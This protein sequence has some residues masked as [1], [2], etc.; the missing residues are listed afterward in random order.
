MA[1]ASTE[2]GV[3]LIAGAQAAGKSTTAELLAR[4]FARCVHLRGAQ[5]YRWAVSGWVHPGDDD[6]ATARRLLDLRYRLSAMA[7]DE[8]ASEG[9]TVVA[10]DT[11]YGTDVEAW[12][13]RIR[14]RPLHL[15]VLRPSVAA[16][17]ARDEERIRTKGKV[18]YRDGF[19][20][21]DNDALVG[22]IPSGL[23]LWLDTSDLTPH[24]VVAEL[25]AREADARVD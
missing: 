12:L 13:G 17:I 22:E 8:Y 10:Q 2:A 19:T 14:A 5:F 25:L 11:I 7:A 3:W 1:R 18:A 15:V 20:P 9:F 21:A 24:G 23:G 4:Q 6:W 16:V